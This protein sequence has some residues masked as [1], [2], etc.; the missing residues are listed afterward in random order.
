MTPDPKKINE[1]LNLS[2]W[3]FCPKAAEHCVHFWDGNPCCYCG[4]DEGPIDS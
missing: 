2:E 1:T 4:S 3:E